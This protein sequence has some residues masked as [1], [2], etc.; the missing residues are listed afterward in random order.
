VTF[1]D[2]HRHLVPSAIA[3]PAVGLASVDAPAAP[4]SGTSSVS[5]PIRTPLDR[6]VALQ[7]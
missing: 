7:I 1:A 2:P 5:H 4:Q 6:L 3:H